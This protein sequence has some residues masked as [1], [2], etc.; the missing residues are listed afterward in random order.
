MDNGSEFTRHALDQ[1]A[2]ARGVKLSFIDPRKPVQNAYVES[3][4][5]TFRFECLDAHW[6]RG[7]VD[8]RRTVESWRVEYN[9]IRPHGSIGKRTPAEYAELINVASAPA[10]LR[11]STSPMEVGTLVHDLKSIYR[12]TTRDAA[13]AALDEVGRGE[14]LMPTHA[15]LPLPPLGDGPCLPCF[16]PLFKL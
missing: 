6:F 15:T 1:W 3:F 12:A 11:P 16:L 8:A 4:N 9:E 7:L 10:A 2:Y 5:G 13:E 14:S